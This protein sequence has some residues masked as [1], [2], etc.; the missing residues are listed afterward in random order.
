M[1]DESA[2]SSGTSSPLVT[3]DWLAAHLADARLRVL[4]IRSAVD[5][6]G[7]AAYEAAHVPGAIHTDYTRDGWRATRGMATGLLPEPEA[8]A[9]LLG[10]LGILPAHHVVI[11]GAG[12]GSG[13]FSAAA[14]VYWTLKTAGHRAVSILDGGMAAWWASSDR[15]MESGS[16]PSISPSSYP[17]RIDR[18]WRSDLAAVAAAVA[19]GGAVL[20]DSRARSFF[21]GMS[22]SPQAKRPGRLPGAILLDHASAFDA[23]G[24]LLPLADIRSLFAAIPE[25]PVINYCNTGHQAA[26]NWFILSELLGRPSATLYDGSMAEWT[27]EAVKACCGKLMH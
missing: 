19:T 24:R 10:S 22:Q 27:E 16:G 7:L 17:V 25:G 14:R 6:G 8:L 23:G 9:C 5:G 4:D 15:S 20:V 26:T 12:T 1:V 3:A 18:S 11:V 13:D 21:E 2:E